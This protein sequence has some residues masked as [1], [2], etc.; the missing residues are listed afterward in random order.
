MRTSRNLSGGESFEVSLAL[1]LGLADMSAGSRRA[2]LGNVLLDE[3]FG[4]LDDEALESA[5][6]LLMELR[7]SDKLV[8]IISHVDKLRERIDTRIEV[9]NRSGVGMLSGAG[10]RRIAGSPDRLPRKKRVRP[11]SEKTPDDLFP[12]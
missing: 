6:E 7:R 11:A 4:T 10:V 12:D 1:A 9:T 8:G 2:S 3:G 5:L